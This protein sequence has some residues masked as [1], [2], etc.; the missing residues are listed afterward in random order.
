M[1][2]KD[3]FISYSRLD[4]HT[5]EAVC[6]A[7]EAAGIGCWIAPRD[8]PAGRSW[9]RDIVEAIRGAKV[10]VLVLSKEAN[11]SA[12]VQREIDIAFEA[13]R[14]IIPFRIE[15]VEIA[16]DLYYCIGS[17]HWLDA[18]TPPLDRH[19]PRLVA[20][21]AGLT[22]MEPPQDGSSQEAPEATSERKHRA[23]L[24]AFD[25]ASAPAEAGKRHTGRRRR[26]LA[27][28]LSS[29]VLAAVAGA[30]LVW[31]DVSGDPILLVD[32]WSESVTLTPNEDMDM[33]AA[34]RSGSRAVQGI[35]LD[36]AL[37]YLRGLEVR[38]PAVSQEVSRPAGDVAIP[39]VLLQYL[40]VSSGCEVQIENTVDKAVRVTIAPVARTAE[41]AGSCSV[42]GQA[43]SR[44]VPDVPE[45]QL[46]APWLE[47]PSDQQLELT[48]MPSPGQPARLE[49]YP[50][51][52]I[53]L[54]RIGVAGLA[55]ETREHGPNVESSILRG[56]IRFPTM[57]NEPVELS[58]RDTLILPE[59][60]GE[61][62]ELTLGDSI[63]SVFRGTSSEPRIA[64]RRLGPD[65]QQRLYQSNS[66]RAVVAV[67]IIALA[68]AAV[69][70]R[71]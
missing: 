27:A 22:I 12:Q 18:L 5:A 68:G 16:E 20:A 70:L 15:D 23:M 44:E 62:L 13:G 1:T 30:I 65:L 31:P 32:L 8:I 59:L 46:L 35:H 4:E 7:L 40:E 71:T 64:A 50:S 19:L 56:S 55:F 53:H 38:V 67:G 9:K 69:W 48:A 21:A 51:E 39:A 26:F 6:V 58:A 33:I 17:R 25:T 54:E 57:A 14:P 49:F 29:G 28:A 10:I 36:P 43:W 52:P 42:R 37:I 47:V 63:R 24:P 11:G 2:S 60:K 3:V 34:A 61:L 66:F 45:W 41:A